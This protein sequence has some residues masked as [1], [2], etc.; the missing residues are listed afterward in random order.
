[1][2]YNLL[3]LLNA[4]FPANEKGVPCID[5]DQVVDFDESDNLFVNR[6]NVAGAV[7]GQEF[8]FDG[9]VAGFVGRSNNLKRVPAAQVVPSNL[10]W[11][12]RHPLRAL[13]HSVI[14]RDVG[15]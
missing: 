14:E 4:F 6:H 11:H 15:H 7:Y 1:M 8:P 13:H 9:I 10:H 5:H 3:D 12:D 2:G